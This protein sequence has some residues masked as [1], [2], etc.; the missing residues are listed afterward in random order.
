MA[1]SR[2]PIT[3]SRGQSPSGFD[4]STYSQALAKSGRIATTAP[5]SLGIERGYADGALGVQLL[6]RRLLGAR[7]DPAK[8]NSGDDPP[9][10]GI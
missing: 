10:F 3:V 2:N 5:A 1:A 9:P 6:G 8:Q 4:Q 7:L